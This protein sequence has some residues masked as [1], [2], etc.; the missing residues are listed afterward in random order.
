MA[1]RQR[2][3]KGGRLPLPACVLKEIRAAVEV[4]AARYDVSRSFVIAVA[5]ADAFG[6]VDQESYLVDEK[7]KRRRP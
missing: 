2:A 1:R 3:I 7:R 5:L 4:T 6:I